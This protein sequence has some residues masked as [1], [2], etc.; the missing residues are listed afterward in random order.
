[1][2][3]CTH[4][5]ILAHAV[6]NLMA[7]GGVANIIANLLSMLVGTDFVT[8]IMAQAVTFVADLQLCL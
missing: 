2:C 8:M 1:M 4:Y 3:A 6:S 5:S 7:C